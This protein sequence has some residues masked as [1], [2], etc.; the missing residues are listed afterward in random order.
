MLSVHMLNPPATPREML[1]LLNV[2]NG[3]TVAGIG[4]IEQLRSMG[5]SVPDEETLAVPRFLSKL[6]D[7]VYDI[8]TNFLRDDAEVESQLPEAIFASIPSAL[9]SLD[10]VT[11][12]AISRT[13]L[14][15]VL[16]TTSGPT[17]SAVLDTVVSLKRRI[18]FGIAAATS[19]SAEDQSIA[20]E[21]VWRL[22]TRACVD[23]VDG[24]VTRIV[25]KPPERNQLP[26]ILIQLLL[27]CLC[28]FDANASEA[29]CAVIL[30]VS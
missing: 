25:E 7:S 17:A 13:L 24:C 4:A 27:D 11:V 10:P 18:A 5:I 1:L 23:A 22:V 29:A 9:Q 30:K 16:R 8:L 6:R 3:Q 2:D 14:R 15:S 19:T 21:H 20:G 12:Y 28:G 26:E